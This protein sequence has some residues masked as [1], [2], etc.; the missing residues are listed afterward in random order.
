LKPLTPIAHALGAPQSRHT[1]STPALILDLDVLERNIATMGQ[2][3]AKFGR[4]LRPHIKSHKCSRI[5]R[6]QVAAG[7]I[8]LCCAT[9]D[10]AEVMAAADLR[11]LL[12]TSSITTRE[13]IFRLMALAPDT[14]IVADHPDNV[15]ALAQAARARGV[16]LGVLVDLEL[17]FGRT[18]VLTVNAVETL[19][20]RIAECSGLKFAGIQAYGGH[21]QHIP[22]HADRVSKAKEAHAFIS[23]VVTRLESVGIEAPLV[24][25][26]GTG[27]HAI[28]GLAGPFTEIQAGSY[29][30]MDADYNAVAFRDDAPWPFDVSLFVQAA[31]VST[32]IAGTV[33][34]D[35]G[36]KALA[37]N[38]PKPQLTNLGLERATY[39]FSGD[40]HGRVRLNGSERAPGIGERL[41]LIVSHCDPTV[42]L[43]DVYHCV[44]GD[45]LVD[46]WPIDARGRR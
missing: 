26:G 14:M 25:G 6:M 30:L 8:G 28:D 35:A 1:V 22:I 13:K 27:T 20:R 16:E 31:V 46:I 12:I 18:G 2:A 24:T 37:L 33:T 29:P 39:E 11:G 17:G 41:E 5:A 21:L 23:Q 42:A 40:E 45:R 36:T 38:G 19:A 3:M 7:A 34:I 32:N 43:Y 44:R 15:E 10:E 4:A 9:L